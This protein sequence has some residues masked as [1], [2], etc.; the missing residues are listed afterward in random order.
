MRYILSWMA[1]DLSLLFH[2]F[3]KKKKKKVKNELNSDAPGLEK[4]TLY[5]PPAKLNTCQMMLP[6]VYWILHE[7]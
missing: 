3:K 1:M 5:L 4:D 7:R 6:S 2:V